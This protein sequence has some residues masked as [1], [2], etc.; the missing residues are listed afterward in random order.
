MV[1][2]W[3]VTSVMSCNLKVIDALL[4]IVCVILYDSQ[5]VGV[6]RL[7]EAIMSS[8]EAND[9]TTEGWDDTLGGGT[10]EQCSPC[11]RGR[12]L[13]AQWGAFRFPF[14]AQVRR[15]LESGR[16]HMIQEKHI[17]S[18]DKHFCVR[19][20]TMMYCDVRRLGSERLILLFARSRIIIWSIRLGS[21][22]F[23]YSEYNLNQHG[24]Y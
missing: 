6:S 20:G 17:Q 15:A 9:M 21:E 10:L 3:W 23:L 8:L 5:K 18:N 24:R 16:H 11:L 13:G 2:E 4:R 1:A 14:P 22:R 7:L 19:L 12:D